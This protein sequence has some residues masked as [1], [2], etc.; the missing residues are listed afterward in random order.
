MFNFYFGDDKYI[1]ENEEDYLVFIKRLMPRW[2][3]SIPDSEFVAIYRLLVNADP[4]TKNGILV[5]TGV[6]A[7]TIIL[8]NHAVKNNTVLYS[9]DTNPNKCAY[10]RSVLNDTVVRRYKINLWDY[11]KCVT[12]NSLSN[13][14]GI[15]VLDELGLSVNFCFLDSE[16]TSKTLLGEIKLLNSLLTDGSVVAIDDANYRFKYANIFLINFQRRELGLPPIENPVNNVTD[17]LHKGV[18]SYLVDK[19]EIV[20]RFDDFFKLQVKEDSFSDFFMGDRTGSVN[21]EGLIDRIK[22]WKIQNRRM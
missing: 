10:I 8:L 9:W 6:G 17:V 2:C 7:S 19:W 16:H 21:V 3:N 12:F 20:E 15:Q 22:A 14:L 5:E 1:D 18:E 13:E 11:W 4:V